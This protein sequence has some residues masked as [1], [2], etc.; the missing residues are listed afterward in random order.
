M[1]TELGSLVKE[2]I[3]TWLKVLSQYL[4]GRTEETHKNPVRIPHLQAET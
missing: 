3:M 2:V 1:N 4:P